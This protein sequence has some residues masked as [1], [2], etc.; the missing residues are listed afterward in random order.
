MYG[1]LCKTPREEA[2]QSQKPKSN[3]SGLRPSTYC[4]YSQSCAIQ[5]LQPHGQMLSIRRQPESG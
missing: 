1:E 3:T 5:A 4:E 2:K